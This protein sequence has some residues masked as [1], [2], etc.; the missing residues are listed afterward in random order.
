M[1]M[2]VK[3]L[4]VAAPPTVRALSVN[5]ARYLSKEYK[6]AY[7]VGSHIL[8]IC[9]RTRKTWIVG[10]LLFRNVLWLSEEKEISII[11]ISSWR[12]IRTSRNVWAPFAFILIFAATMAKNASWIVPPTPYHLYYQKYCHVLNET[13]R[14][15]YHGPDIPANHQVTFNTAIYRDRSSPNVYAAVLDCRSVALHVQALTLWTECGMNKLSQ[16]N[17]DNRT[18]M[19]QQTR[20]GFAMHAN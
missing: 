2:P 5:V 1:F 10:V 13:A 3:A 15:T 8:S 18:H 17:R 9:T 11:C 12:S 7:V 4:T 16:E 6:G 14:D 20:P 19:P